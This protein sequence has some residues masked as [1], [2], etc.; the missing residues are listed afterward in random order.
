MNLKVSKK[1]YTKIY[2]YEKEDQTVTFK[3]KNTQ[4]KNIEEAGITSLSTT[5]PRGHVHFSFN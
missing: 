2:I 4:T 3:L 1:I 5:I